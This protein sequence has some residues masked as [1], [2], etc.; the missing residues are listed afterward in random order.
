MDKSR[1]GSAGTWETLGS[2][3]GK[4][5]NEL[6][7]GAPCPLLPRGVAMSDPSVG[8]G[9]CH[10]VGG[11]EPGRGLTAGLCLKWTSAPDSFC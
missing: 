8:G 4:A 11:V 6:H 1:E 10:G 7:A 2:G 3:R 5:A 9:D